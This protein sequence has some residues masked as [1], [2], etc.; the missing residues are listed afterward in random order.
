M[1]ID[2][3]KPDFISD[4]NFMRI[5]I[6][7]N[8]CDELLPFL[9]QA[10][11]FL[12]KRNFLIWLELN[13]HCIYFINHH[14]FF[15]FF[16]LDKVRASGACVLVHC[17]AGISRSATVAI[18]YVMRDLKLSFDY[19]YR[20]VILLSNQCIAMI[21]WLTKQGTIMFHVTFD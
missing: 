10:F 4:S 15:L 11:E 16:S 6:Q 20:W 14:L 9:P 19:A 7:D 3:P 13:F 21:A 5:P 12:G 1:S 8:Y 18:S 2:C 17:F